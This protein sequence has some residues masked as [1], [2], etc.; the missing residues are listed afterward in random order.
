MNPTDGKTTH[1]VCDFCGRQV[2][3]SYLNQHYKTKIC[4]T[5][6]ENAVP[7]ESKKPKEVLEKYKIGNK[8]KKKKQIDTLGVDGLRLKW[9]L[10]RQLTRAKNKAP[11]DFTPEAKTES[12]HLDN[13]LNKLSDILV[14]QKNELIEVAKTT[15]IQKI[16]SLCKESKDD[17]KKIQNQITQINQIKTKEIFLKQFIET[18]GLKSPTALQ[19][20]NDFY[21]FT[22]KYTNKE[23]DFTRLDW[24]KDYV[25]IYNFILKDRKA[26]GTE[27]KETST[28]TLLTCLGSIT[29]VLG[30]DFDES[31]SKYKLLARNYSKNIQKDQQENKLSNEQRLK[32]ISWENL[33]KMEPLFLDSNGGTTFTRAIYSIYTK[34][35]PRRAKD[36]R[37]MKVVIKKNA[38]DT[39]DITR[40]NTAYNY[41]ICSQNIL[42][43]RLVFN[44]FKTV[45]KRDYGQ[46]VI[47]KIPPD[48]SK[49]LK[50][51]IVESDLKSGNF[52][53]H[54]EHNKNLEYT[55]G[56]FSKLI[57]E[58]IF[59][60]YSGQRID[61]NSIRHA[62]VSHVMTQKLS[63]N[64]LERIAKSMG[65]SRNELFSVYNKLDI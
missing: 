39:V 12:K 14:L 63:S 51:Y 4:L 57:S 28:R 46:Y 35:A 9:K 6:R 44:T 52:L 23:V 21:K 64:E 17:S 62:Y 45:S 48:L 43:T 32:A 5:A 56:N 59:Q 18:T 33:L 13:Q 38:K 29:S 36:Y 42:P 20:V 37:L 19:Y 34:I 1:I 41:C 55:Q 16:P 24:L 7:Y 61:I 27:Y 30:V 25:K 3:K 40:L 8:L 50:E 49:V 65:T 60:L 2:A 10:A 26:D 53:F 58:E 15:N 31:S 47:D 54:Q 11:D 22:K